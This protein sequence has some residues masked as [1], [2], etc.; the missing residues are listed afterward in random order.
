VS[1]D[2]VRQFG[3]ID[4]EAARDRHVVGAVEPA[5]V[6]ILVET[7]DVAGLHPA[8]DDALGQSIALI[9]DLQLG[10]RQRHAAG[11]QRLR[12]GHVLGEPL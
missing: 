1:S 3:R 4:V 9:R 10:E 2:H 7:S 11:V 8:I 5:E 6:A 12:A